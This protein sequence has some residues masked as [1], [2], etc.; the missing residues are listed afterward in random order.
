MEMALLKVHNVITLNIYIM[1]TAL[2]LI[3]R[4]RL[5]LLIGTISMDP[6]PFLYGGSGVV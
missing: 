2:A 4:L 1:V 6:F 3:S 5:L